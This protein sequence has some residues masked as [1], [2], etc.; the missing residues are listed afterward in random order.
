MTHLEFHEL[1]ADYLDGALGERQAS[2]FE[3]H[4]AA[5]VECREMAADARF[6]FDACQAAEF[7]EPPPWLVPRILRAT[8]GEQRPSFA[9]RLV[10]WAR[11]ALRP[12][13][14][15]GV[16]MAVF[17]LSFLLYTSG[18]R[19]NEVKLQ[20]VNPATWLRHADRKGHLL[21]ARAEKFYYDLRVVYEVQSLL[22]GFENQPAAQ[23]APHPPNQP[24]GGANNMNSPSPR[25]LAWNLPGV[26]Q[27]CSLSLQ[28]FFGSALRGTSTKSVNADNRY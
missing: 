26:T 13:V 2:D 21:A 8:V 6:A 16:S 5:C 3:A 17:S 27:T 14:A 22:S 12:Q 28:P 10:E 11:H 7:L 18:A 9:G 4:L 25:R 20:D 19:V 24:K 15:Y 1:L 23:P